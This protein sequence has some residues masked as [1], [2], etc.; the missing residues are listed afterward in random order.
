MR[1][2]RRPRPL[3]M[4]IIVFNVFACGKAAAQTTGQFQLGTWGGRLEAGYETEHERAVSPGSPPANFSLQRFDEQL[5]VE[6]DGFYYI[7][8]RLATGSLA[9]TFGLFQE[10]QSSSNSQSA[11]HGNLIGYAFDS[12]LFSTLPYT[13]N[14]YANRAE[15]VISQP[16]GRSDIT[17]E[18]RGARFNLRENSILRDWGL[19][20]LT[21]TVWVE[22]QSTDEN[23]TSTLGQSFRREE[24][25]TTLGFDGHKGFQTS[26]LDWRY[27][28]AD[29]SDPYNPQNNFHSQSGT[30]NF[31]LDFGQRRNRHW[32]SRLQYYGRDGV[33]AYSTATSS[34]SLRIEHLTNLTSTYDYDYARFQST[35]GSSSTQTGALG[36]SYRPYSNLSTDARLS[37]SRD[38][39]PEGSR[40]DYE[41]RLG[42]QYQRSLP[43]NGR[44]SLQ[45]SGGYRLNENRLTASLINVIDERHAA[46]SSFGAG[47]GVPLDQSFPIE[48]SIVVVDTRGGA[49]LPT[50]LGLDYEILQEGNL[51]RIV[52]LVTSAVIQPGDPL[53]VSYSYRLDPSIKYRTVLASAGGG[54]NYGWISVSVQ[55]DQSDQTLLSGQTDQFLENL[56]RDSAQVEL[57]GRYRSVR[58]QAG[59]QFVLYDATRLAYR[60]ERFYGSA[61][62]QA[63]RNLDLGLNSDWTRTEFTILPTHLTVA[64]SIQATAN[65]FG[66]RHRWSVLGLLSRRLF[67]DSL[68]QAEAVNEATVRAR[69][70]YGKLT[71]ASAFTFSDRTLGQF[72]SDSWRVHCNVIRRL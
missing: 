4:A 35:L 21:S 7:D 65:W 22:Q 16:F 48:S 67:R 37:G 41:T 17:F 34:Q 52:P 32:D 38:A 19:P 12:T 26:D 46:P 61:Y 59:S 69:L 30:F 3:S 1:S 15:N 60:Q 53:L 31:N 58:G 70:D 45:S 25:Q 29:T 62:Y 14:L 47:N 54:V 6:N 72:R 10:S 55:H 71:L 24:L 39:L 63:A 18:S 11:G 44:L 9:L 51:S 66:L 43:D 27:L 2:M 36:L 42:L 20:Y 28:Y 33:S 5:T 68:V 13:G 57:Q 40:T 8:P 49:R 64:S 56:R 23:T 50:V